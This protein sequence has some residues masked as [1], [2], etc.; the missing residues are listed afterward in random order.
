MILL[1]NLDLKSKEG[2]RAVHLGSGQLGFLAVHSGGRS[3]DV[4]ISVIYRK[5]EQ[6]FGFSFPDKGF[7]HLSLPLGAQ[8]T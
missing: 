6:S 2:R 5:F 7:G 1:L 8:P 4:V 3:D